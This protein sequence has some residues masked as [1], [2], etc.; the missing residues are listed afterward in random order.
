ML[1]IFGTIPPPARTTPSPIQLMWKN[2]IQDAKIAVEKEQ[3]KR[4]IDLALRHYPG[5]LV[6]KDIFERMKDLPS[7]VRFLVYRKKPKRWEGPVNLILVERYT[8]V[9]RLNR[10]KKIFRTTWVKPWVNSRISRRGQVTKMM[11]EEAMATGERKGGGK[12]MEPVE[13]KNVTIL[14]IEQ[15]EGDEDI[16]IGNKPVQIEGEERIP[17]GEGFRQLQNR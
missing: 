5:V 7:G 1:L 12:F 10:D 6:M 3:L 11:D 16:N 15:G 17:G 8:A 13:E 9:I 2:S 14:M 4:R